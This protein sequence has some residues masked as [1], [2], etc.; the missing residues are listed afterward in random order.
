RQ[1][2]SQRLSVNKFRCN[3]M[4]AV[5]LIYLKNGNDV[6]MVERRG[7]ARL[8]FEALHPLSISSEL[9]RQEFERQLASEP[10][11]LREVNFSHSARPQR[12]KN[13]VAANHPPYQRLR[14]IFGYGLGCDLQGGPIQEVLGLLRLFVRR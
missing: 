1:P 14:L 3:E 7:R 2:L 12:R 6:R 10:G 4:G 8:L 5:D 13:L 9:L 11:I